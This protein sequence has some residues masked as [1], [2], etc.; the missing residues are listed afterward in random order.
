[1]KLIW[2]KF[3]LKSKY[4]DIFQRKIGY[5][6]CPE[7]KYPIRKYYNYFSYIFI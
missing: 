7:L 2:N 5:V 3:K 4:S 1:M 6:L